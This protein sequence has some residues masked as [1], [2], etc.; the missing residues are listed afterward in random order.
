M[1][2][3]IALDTAVHEHPSVLAIVLHWMVTGYMNE[4]KGETGLLIPWAMLGLGLLATTRTRQLL[5]HRKQRLPNWLAS[6]GATL[7]RG[8]TKNVL[9]AWRDPFWDAAAMGCASGVLFLDK[10]RVLA[11]G[12]PG[13]PTSG[14]LAAELRSKGLALGKTFA[15]EP[16]DRLITSALGLEFST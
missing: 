11:H 14:G 5:P 4:L 8:N 15:T 10:G 9:L 13:K 2:Q 1:T 16:D 6:D 7:W 12:K 3:I